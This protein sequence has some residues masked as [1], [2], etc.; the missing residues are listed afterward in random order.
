MIFLGGG[1]FAFQMYMRFK[2]PNAFVED[3]TEYLYIPTGTDFEQ[4]MVLVEQQGSVKNTSSFR[5][6]ALQLNLDSHLNPGR[7]KVEDGMNNLDLVRLIRSGRQTPVRLVFNKVRLKEDFASL[8]SKKL[9]IDS[10]ALLLALQDEVYLRQYG[11]TPQTA[12]TLF[13]PN[14]YEFYWNTSLNKFFDKMAAEHSKVWNE[15]RIA[16]ATKL[17]LSPVEVSVLA[18]IVEEETNAHDEKNL[19]ASVYLNRLRKGMLLQADP[20]V[21][22]AVGDFTIKRVTGK[23]TATVSDYNTYV[24][25]GLPPGPICTP[26]LKSIDAVLNATQ[27]EYLFFCADPSRPG[28]HAFAK[29]WT[30]H[31]RNAARYHAYLKGLGL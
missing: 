21:K 28:Y 9:E 4:L 16:K 14:T 22:Y 26:S 17:E 7:Y 13:I 11:Q 2:A 25:K 30:E 27:S 23:H 15:E 1:F 24:S 3:T 5:K 12:L 29:T 19:I 18:S 6:A 20:T 8:V 10:L 31:K